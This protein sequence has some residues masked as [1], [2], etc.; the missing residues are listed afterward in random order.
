MGFSTLDLVMILLGILSTIF[1]L[2]FYLKS[3]KY[4]SLFAGLDSDEFTLKEIYSIGYAFLETVHFNFQNSTSKRGQKLRQ[5]L[6]VLYDEKYVEYYVRV[7]YSQCAAFAV[8][9]LPL[10]FAF[11][12][13]A[14]DIMAF[15]LVVVV[16]GVL[17]YYFYTL[18][19][20]KIEDRSE[21][22]LNDFSDV[23][24]NLALL[25]N[26]GMILHEAWEATAETGTGPLFDEMKLVL[27]DVRN[28]VSETE[29]IRRFGVRCII[30]EIRK[31]ASTLIQGIEKG[32]KEIA[33]ALRQQ[34]AEL[35]NVK[36]QNVKRKGETA[37]SKLLFPMIIMFA[38][39]LIIIVVPIFANLG[40]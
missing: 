4:D 1:F 14:H 21:L 17:I 19:S 32:N 11:Y 25:T 2:F 35:W 12:G 29:A 3:G 39:V 23:V 22:L 20:S 24:S 31:F 37:A 10:A 7:I 9:L 34:S 26:A 36:K 40:V 13:L 28:G 30:P 18:S 8:T 33:I 15:A 6:R 5:E 16:G 38:G 27:E